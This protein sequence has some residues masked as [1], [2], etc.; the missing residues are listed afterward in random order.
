LGISQLL[1]ILQINLA[2]NCTVYVSW[3]SQ[4]PLQIAKALGPGGVNDYS[5]WSFTYTPAYHAIRNGTNELIA[6]IS[7]LDEDNNNNNNTN[8]TAAYLTNYYS[9]NIIG[10]IEPFSSSERNT[11]A[12][13][14]QHNNGAVFRLLYLL[15]GDII[16]MIIILNRKHQHSKN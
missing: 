4:N 13:G 11:A 15:S 10:T 8:N 6:Q 2:T 9:I 16:S 7:C 12:Q 5:T 14:E 3:D 1:G